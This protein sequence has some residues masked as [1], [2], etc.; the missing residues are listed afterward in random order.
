M[1]L[2]I[3]HRGAPALAPENT[4][5][6][7]ERALALG[8]DG[9]EFDVRAGRD[10]RLEVAHDP[11]TDAGLALDDALAFFAGNEGIVHVDLK[12]PGRE[13]DLVAA[14]R[15]HGL[16]ERALVSSFRPQSLRALAAVEPRLARSLTYPEDRLGVAGRRALALA[17]R[18]GLAAIRRVLPR[19]IGGMLV[20]ARAS[21]ATLH[22]AV[23]T[24]ETVEACH[25]RGAA[26]WVWTVNEPEL[27]AAL[28]ETG[29]DA[30]IS[31]DPRIFRVPSG[32][33]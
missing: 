20:R 11:G 23:V 6:S 29:A 5:E 18:G 12:T 9:V 8:V 7:F 1:P 2:R 21:A 30:I 26:V 22:F 14:L 27:A 4:L 3:G 13:V 24:R 16:L 33:T 31:D 25:A 17:I 19:R 15:R 32:K 10:H 28:A